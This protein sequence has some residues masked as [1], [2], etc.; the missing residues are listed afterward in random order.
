MAGT[1]GL[2]WNVAERETAFIWTCCFYCPNT[3]KLDLHDCLPSVYGSL[4]VAAGV[5]LAVPA[6]GLGCEASQVGHFWSVNVQRC[7]GAAYRDLGRTATGV[8][9]GVDHVGLSLPHLPRLCAVQGLHL[10]AVRHR[11]DVVGEWEVLW[12]IAKL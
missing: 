4:T 6:L 8:P 7:G 5:L 12:E 11:C 9:N 3:T 1:D 2:P 10:V